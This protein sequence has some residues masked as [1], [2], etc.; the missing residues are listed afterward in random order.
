M[1]TDRDLAYWQAREAEAYR[2]GI[3]IG[4]WATEWACRILLGKPNG[5]KSWRTIMRRG[6]TTLRSMRWQVIH[7]ARR[8]VG[9][10]AQ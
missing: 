1:M 3:A 2:N 7:A 9:R 6:D 10:D 4:I 5:R 8:I